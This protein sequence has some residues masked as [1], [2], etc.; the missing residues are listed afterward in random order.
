MKYQVIGP[1][2]PVATV[3]SPEDAIALGRRHV[4]LQSWFIP[5]HV[6]RLKSGKNTVWNYGF[7]TLE[8]HCQPDA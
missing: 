1:L 5:E 8:I 6:L 4:W 3:S 2:G 7:N